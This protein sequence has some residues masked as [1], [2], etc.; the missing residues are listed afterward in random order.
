MPAAEWIWWLRR[1]RTPGALC[2]YAWSRTI[3]LPVLQFSFRFKSA[4]R[5]DWNS[6]FAY[7]KVLMVTMQSLQN[8]QLI[9]CTIVI[10]DS[11]LNKTYKRVNITPRKLLT[12]SETMKL[13]APFKPKT[14]GEPKQLQLFG[15]DTKESRTHESVRYQSLACNSG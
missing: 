15:H 7:S 12:Y 5:F 10:L 2:W 14:I 8:H 3:E 4:I 11:N 6:V 9:Y 1:C 13:V